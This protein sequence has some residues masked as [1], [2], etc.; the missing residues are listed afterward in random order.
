[1]TTKAKVTGSKAK[2]TMSLKGG[3]LPDDF[4][5]KIPT[6]IDYEGVTMQTLMEVCSGGQSARV[7]LQSQL[8]SRRVPD[9]I[10]MANEG[11]VIK[12]A[13]ILKGVTQSPVDLMLAL[14]LEDFIATME[15]LGV[16]RFN[17]TNIYNKKH[18]LQ[19]QVQEEDEEETEE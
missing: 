12:I 3:K 4:V 1:M 14:G 10:K 16:D 7:M 2:F 5:A 19:E 13:D 9:L 11:L 15:G 17:A 8:R 18:G 6:T